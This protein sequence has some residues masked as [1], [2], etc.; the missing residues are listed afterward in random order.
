MIFRT[1]RRIGGGRMTNVSAIGLATLI[2]VIA[3]SP[4]IGWAGPLDDRVAAAV[5]ETREQFKDEKL[6]DEDVAVTL[7]ELDRNGESR[8][9]SFRGDAP[10]FPASVV[11]LFYLAAA[12]RWLE[13]GKLSDSEELRR[14]MSDM[15]VDSSNDATAMFVE[16][17]T[18][19]PGGEPLPPA[20]MK[21]WSQK[22][23]AVNDYFASLGYTIGGGQ[24]INV[25][26][27]TY[28]EGPYGRERIFLGEKFDNRNKLTTDATARLLSE[29]ALDKS[30]TPARSKQMMKL[31]QRDRTAKSGGP[32]DQAHGFIAKVLAPGDK[33]WSK[34]GWT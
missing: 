6:R 28:C 1:I 21:Q 22:R 18:Q 31:L 24:G 15:I 13:D 12:H 34:A 30:V 23:N 19:A 27:K 33:L 16:A 32:D 8:S 9:G 14:A 4:L 5:R 7:I 20:E 2:A 29:I 26:Q 25:C 10:T 17:L 3:A 11:K